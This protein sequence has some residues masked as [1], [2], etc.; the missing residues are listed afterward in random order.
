M[1]KDALE[2][3]SHGSSS[4]DL[5]SAHLCFLLHSH[6]SNFSPL[7]Y[8]VLSEHFFIKDNYKLFCQC[9]DKLLCCSCG[10]VDWTTC[11]LFLWNININSTLNYILAGSK[12]VLSLNRGL[13]TMYF[14]LFYAIMSC[15]KSMQYS[16]CRNGKEWL[17]FIHFP[18][19]VDNGTCCRS[20]S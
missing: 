11:S 6:F 13:Y 12:L 18:V 7:S 9:D 16:H 2:S 3:F 17:S 15:P 5:L 14:F 1:G 19:Y 4:C 10:K 20:H 8:T